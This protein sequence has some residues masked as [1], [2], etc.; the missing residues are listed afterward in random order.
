MNDQLIADL[1]RRLG[2]S[3]LFVW[4]E[5]QA[6]ALAAQGWQ[7]EQGWL[8]FT[9]R[10]L[11]A[12]NVA[13]IKEAD[14]RIVGEAFIDWK[15]G[16]YVVYRRA[17]LPEDTARFAVAHELA[18][19]YWFQHGAGL[20]PLSPLQSL[21][22]RDST[23]ETLCDQFAAALLVP[24]SHLERS[25]TRL[26]GSGV[27]EGIGLALVPQLAMEYRVPEKLIAR[28]LLLG[29]EQRSLVIVRVRRNG[30]KWL[31]SWCAM[32][33]ELRN[34]GAVAGYR[35]PATSN[36]RVLPDEWIPRVAE[37]VEKRCSLDGRWW[38]IATPQPTEIGRLPFARWREA[39]RRNGYAFGYL[40]RWMLVALPLHETGGR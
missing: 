40:D 37:G 20:K 28:R 17:G 36:G 33:Q 7:L 34:Q 15:D 6:A 27:S 3:D 24:R 35:I 25:V 13:S 31:T 38:Q 19:T 22:R 18:H 23:I 12:R 4:I 9:P 8:A 5:E 10:L 21:D 30:Q 29:I 32:P 16:Q 26:R 1:E 14:R 11:S 39:T 2:V